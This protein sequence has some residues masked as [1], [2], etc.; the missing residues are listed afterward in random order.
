MALDVLKVWVIYSLQSSII[1]EHFN[2]DIKNETRYY[3]L[4]GP[5]DEGGVSHPEPVFTKRRSEGSDWRVLDA[6]GGYS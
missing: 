5:Q 6:Q 3:K 4:K 1:A 2:I